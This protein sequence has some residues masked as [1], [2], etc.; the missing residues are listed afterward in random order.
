MHQ[1]TNDYRD[2]ELINLEPETPGGPY[3]VVQE[4]FDSHDPN[5]R[6]AVFYLQQDGCWIEEIAHSILPEERK[7]DMVFETLADVME[8]LEGLTEPPEV[9]RITVTPEQIEAF[10][11][12]LRAAGDAHTF[13]RSFLHRYRAMQHPPA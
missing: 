3:A 5:M 11:A 9:E 8:T 7:F 6:T 12:R 2:C 1:L 4:A 13:I 10:L